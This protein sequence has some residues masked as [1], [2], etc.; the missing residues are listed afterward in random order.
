MD[1]YGLILGLKKWEATISPTSKYTN[2]NTNTIKI[3]WYWNKN[4]FSDQSNKIQNT[5][6]NPQVYGQLISDK[7]AKDLRWNKE[8]AS[9]KNNVEKSGWCMHKINS[10]LFLITCSKSQTKIH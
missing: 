1:S 10:N 8:K 2:T 7:G 3:V 9:S 5:D 4:R 6:I